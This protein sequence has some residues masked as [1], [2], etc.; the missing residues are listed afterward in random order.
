MFGRA[1]ILNVIDEDHIIDYRLYFVDSCNRTI[2]DPIA[3]VNKTVQDVSC[4]RLDTYR[5]VVD[6]ALAP[7]ETN[8]QLMIRAGLIGDEDAIGYRIV[9]PGISVGLRLTAGSRRAA[10]AGTVSLLLVMLS[11][12]TWIRGGA[13]T[14]GFA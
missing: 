10:R 1:S 13:Q 9:D 14:L 3:V 7:V 11:A 5:F 4:C 2:G 8:W 12:L 6:F